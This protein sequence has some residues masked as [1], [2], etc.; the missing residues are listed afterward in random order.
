MLRLHARHLPNLITGL[1]LLLVP[2]ILW[3]LWQQAHGAAL[4]LFIIAGVSDALDGALARGF[5][6]QSRLGGILDPIADKS[7]LIG[8]FVVLGLNGELP[9]WLV[10]LVIGRDLVIVAGAAAWQWLI[11]ELHAAPSL[12]SKLNTAAQLA[13]VCA[14][15]ASHGAVALPH[16]L[17]RLLEWTAAFTTLWSGVDYV[18]RWGRRARRHARG[19]A[20][21]DGR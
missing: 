1:R 17:L 8:C 16:W 5:H 14:V 2:P 11:A 18:L 7:L 10:V 15:L 12:I 4:T 13:V 6:W 21:H 20:V 19:E 3:L 9:A